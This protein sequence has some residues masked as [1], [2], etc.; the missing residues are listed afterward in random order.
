MPGSVPRPPGVSFCTVIRPKRLLRCRGG[1]PAAIP[2]RSCTTDPVPTSVLKQLADD[3]APFLI[4]AL[5]NRSMTEGAVPAAFK[6]PFITPSLKK[7][8]LD[9]TDVRSFRPISNLSVIS[10]LLERLV[11]RRLLKYL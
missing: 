6:V 7:P 10:K 11:A 1:Y 2:S 8:D 4:S 9:A 3:V 5:F